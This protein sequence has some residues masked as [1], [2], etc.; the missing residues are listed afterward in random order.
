MLA[1]LVAW[2]ADQATFD[3]VHK[4]VWKMFSSWDTCLLS[5]AA[6]APFARQ[7]EEQTLADMVRRERL[8]AA[9]E[10]ADGSTPLQALLGQLLQ[11]RALQELEELALGREE[12]R[13]AGS[14]AAKSGAAVAVAPAAWAM[15]AGTAVV[16]VDTP[17]LAAEFA[18]VCQAETTTLVGIDCEWRHPR[19][20]SL[21]QVSQLAV[22]RVLK[23]HSSKL[24]H[25]TM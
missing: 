4:G 12:A 15:P 3:Q 18:R 19:A 2:C 23:T 24:P 10:Y 7:V 5:S 9:A 22:N 20:V 14:D 8:R 21:V 11:P 17:A 13:V 6:Y 25:I 1:A 16:F